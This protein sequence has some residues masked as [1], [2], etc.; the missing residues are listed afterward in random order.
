[1]GSCSWVDGMRLAL[2]KPV[3]LSR[4]IAQNLNRRMDL[5]VEYER[6][7]G[8]RRATRRR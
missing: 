7:N 8:K 4:F 3:R 6:G 5:D 1:M 2:P